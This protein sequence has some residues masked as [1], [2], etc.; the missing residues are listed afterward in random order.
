MRIIKIV[1]LLF[2]AAGL[3]AIFSTQACTRVLWNANQL[4]VLVGRSMDWP[5]ST[6]PVITV[7]PRGIVR[8]GSYLGPEKV[9]AENGLKWTAKYGSLIT[10]V[11]GLGSADG[12]NERGL[13]AHLLYFTA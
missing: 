6:H 3:P 12:L 1:V 13:A 5:E 9:V 10:S 2:A 4:A 11:Y 7:L 8:D